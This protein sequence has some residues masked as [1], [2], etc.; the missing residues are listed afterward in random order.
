VNN[1]ES[2]EPRARHG[3]RFAKV[4]FSLAHLDFDRFR[5]TCT[6]ALALKPLE[7]TVARWI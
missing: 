3:V 4:S 2:C 5:K 7:Q 6:R 1:V